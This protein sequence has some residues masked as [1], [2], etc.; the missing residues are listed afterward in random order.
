M[1]VIADASPLNYLVLINEVHILPKLYGRVLIPPGVWA[2]LQQERTPEPVR[3]WAA[4]PPEWLEV[5]TPHQ[6]VDEQLL[7]LGRAYGPEIRSAC[8]YTISLPQT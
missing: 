5:R 1:I 6:A 2:E 4:K 3:Q 7:S 8:L